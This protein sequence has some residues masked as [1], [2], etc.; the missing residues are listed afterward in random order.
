MKSEQGIILLG[1]LVK[2]V[3]T[4]T[5]Q[6]EAIQIRLESV[7]ESGKE[8]FIQFLKVDNFW[9]YCKVRKK[10]PMVFFNITSS[11]GSVGVK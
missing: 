7:G 2:Q 3:K 1:L 8:F 9:K 4:L 10:P 11:G 5:S 6:V